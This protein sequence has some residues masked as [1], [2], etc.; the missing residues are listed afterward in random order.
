MTEHAH[1]QVHL[2]V[3]I[4]VYACKR[5]INIHIQVHIVS[6]CTYKGIIS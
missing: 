2:L 5:S 1:V 4:H 3:H 6:T